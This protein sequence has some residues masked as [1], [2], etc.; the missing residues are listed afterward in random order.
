MS[1]IKDMPDQEVKPKAMTSIEKVQMMHLMASAA[2]DPDIKEL[3]TSK[4]MGE[5]VYQ[6]FVD[7][8]DFKI[9]EIMDGAI[10]EIQSDLNQ[11]NKSMEVLRKSMDEFH[12]LMV[13]FMG[14]PL[15]DVLKVMNNNLLSGRNP[16]GQQAQV[17][18]NQPQQLV[19]EDP[20]LREERIR[21]MSEDE[22][23]NGRAVG[24]Q[25]GIRRTTLGTL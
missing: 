1:E 24:R 5:E 7:A 13:N 18:S 17:K 21:Q 4:K 16:S 3:I 6:I 8:I 10:T 11:T 9:K 19:I 25:Q 2:T 22:K 20:S 15:V 12:S 14:T 23:N